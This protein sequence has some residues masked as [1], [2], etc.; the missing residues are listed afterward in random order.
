MFERA[1]AQALSAQLDLV[2]G[3]SGDWALVTAGTEA[4]GWNTMTI[5]W[6]S[7]GTLWSTPVVT[8]YVH[9]KR[10]THEFLM[11]EAYFT[12]QLFDGEYKRDLGIL[13]SKSGRDGNKVALTSLTPK[14]IEHGMTFEEAKT[15]IVCRKIYTHHMD[16]AEVPSE[17]RDH[18]RGGLYE[19]E[20]H[21]VFVGEVVNVLS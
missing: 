6:G 11:R 10:F 20:A 18:M 15:T 9:P 4:T 1:T 19:R 7:A 21:T 2:A 13:G 16:L 8:V 12:V 14:A 3:V 5:G 17:V